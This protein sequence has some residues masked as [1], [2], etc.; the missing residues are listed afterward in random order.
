MA[1]S[2]LIQDVNMVIKE[3]IFSEHELQDDEY[4]QAI[5]LL[6]DESADNFCH[7]SSSSHIS[8]EIGDNKQGL[9]SETVPND[10]YSLNDTYSTAT[11]VFGMMNFNSPNSNGSLTESTYS[12]YVLN[13][14]HTQYNI[15]NLV[16]GRI[17]PPAMNISRVDSRVGGDFNMTNPINQNQIAKL[18]Y[19]P[20]IESRLKYLSRI[21]RMLPHHVNSGDK[22]SIT[23][24]IEEGFLPNCTILIPAMT[25]EDIGR[26]KIISFLENRISLFPD[27]VISFS[28]FTLHN[29]RIM[30]AKV[31]I[32]AT[33]I[34]GLQNS[35][36]NTED[37]ITCFPAK[38]NDKKYSKERLKAL[39]L[40]QQRQL[41]SFKEHSLL[42][43]TLNEERTHIA[44]FA[45]L[46]QDI[47]IA[48]YG[49][50]KQIQGGDLFVT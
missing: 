33:S 28:P 22:Q 2:Y 34:V 17:L 12:A 25:N 7:L 30:S 9:V 3:E 4:A 43:F 6:T 42:Y 45:L 18:Y 39:T 29:S 41:F 26:E 10:K 40:F 35:S 15:S 20:L 1:R 47:K 24:V 38:N 21:L 5:K 13:D 16:Y 48:E 44:K 23:S 49:N 31:T 46:R 8:T 37:C 19:N 14:V 11:N 50:H 32:S 27:L 36:N